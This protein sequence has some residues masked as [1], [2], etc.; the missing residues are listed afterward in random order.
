MLVHRQRVL[1]EVVVGAEPRLPSVGPC[2]KSL[3]ACQPC[4]AGCE[5]LGGNR[6][7]GHVLWPVMPATTQHSYALR[8]AYCERAWGATALTALTMVD[9]GDVAP[10]SVS[11]F[12]FFCLSVACAPCSLGSAPAV[13]LIS[14]PFAAAL[15][16]CRAALRL[17]LSLFLSVCLSGSLLLVCLSCLDFRFSCFGLSPVGLPDPSWLPWN[18]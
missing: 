16:G 9:S 6:V 3:T 13:L 2:G 12:L 17:S 14:A 7:V 1:N 10:G 8:L 5:R 15:V 18:C 4:V 11:P